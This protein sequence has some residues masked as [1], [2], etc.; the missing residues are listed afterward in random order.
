MLPVMPFGGGTAIATPLFAAGLDWLEALLPALFVIIWIVSQIAGVVKKLTGE[1]P[2]APAPRP[3][4]A[5]RP[6]EMARAGPPLPRQPRPA[7]AGIDAELRREI[8]Q[9]LQGRPTEPIQ[10]GEAGPQSMPPPIPKPVGKRPPRRQPVRSA[11]TPR[12]DVGKTPIAEMPHLTSSLTAAT[13]VES[14][15]QPTA[16]SVAVA[17]TIAG[18][19]ADPRSLRQAI[20]LREVLDRPVERWS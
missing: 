18:L 5:A 6:A 13:N 16:A 20:V 15:P 7:N 12:A 14:R 3:R 2:A 17:G 1:K 8:E 11:Q 9:F 19:L 10:I 4:P